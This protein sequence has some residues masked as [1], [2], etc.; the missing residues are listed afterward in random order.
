MSGKT[1]GIA[2]ILA[3]VLANTGCVSCCHKTYKQARENAP[4]CELPTPCRNQ[5][6]VFMVHGLTPSTSSGLDALRTKLGESGFAKVGVGELTSAL[7]IVF[8]IKDIYK[9]DPD[10]KFVL[11]GY[12]LGGGAAQCLARELS[13]R[14]VPIEGLVLLDPLAC[15]EPC[16]ARTLLITS[17]TTISSAPCT[18]RLAVPDASHYRLPAHPATVAAITELLKDLATRNWQ[19]AP[20]PVPEFTYPLAPEMRPVLQSRPGE[21][22]DFLADRQ[23]PVP[24]INTRTVTRPVPA[25]TPV[26]AAGPVVI[27]P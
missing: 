25:Q 6:Y 27:K 12:D 21:E 15:G 22:W 16:S 4:D 24:S 18:N 3:M 1:W 19:A 14:G 5:I 23:G 10:A 7:E 2:A 8:E 26:T 13:A 20:D 9:C 17:G 11:I